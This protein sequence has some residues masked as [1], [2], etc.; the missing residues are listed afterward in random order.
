MVLATLYISRNKMLYNII[1]PQLTIYLLTNL[2]TYLLTPRS[3]ALLEK[4]TVSQLV[5][6]FPAFYGTRRFITTVT[7][8][9]H[10]SLPWASSIQ[11][12]PPHPTSWRSILILSYHLRL[13]LLSGLVPSSFPT[14]TLYKPLLTPIR[15]IWPTDLILLHLNT[16]TQ[17][18]EEYR[19]LSSSLCIF[20]HSPGTSSLLGPNIFLD[21]LYVE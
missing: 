2:L 10:L 18:G 13:D 6:K 11:S 3:T 21:T 8:A 12:I 1:L 5:K 15:A 20:L 4:L 17:S 14:K 19:S 9:R 16:R 7:S